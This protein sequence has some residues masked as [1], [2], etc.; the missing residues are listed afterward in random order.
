MHFFTHKRHLLLCCLICSMFFVLTACTSTPQ[1]EPVPPLKETRFLMG[2]AI[3]LTLF[4]GQDEAT[5]AKAFDAIEALERDLSLNASG[6]LLDEVNDASGIAPVAVNPSMFDVVEKGLYY[7][8]L[9]EGSF[10]IS[11]GPL[12]KLWNIGFPD[13]RVPSQSEIDATLPL[14]DYEQVQLDRHA[15]T[16]FLT[17]PGMKLDLGS[18]AKGYAA[19]VVATL[20]RE[21]GVQHALIDLG[22]NIYTLGTKL[23][24][25]PWKVGVQDPFNPRGKI[26]G[27][28]PVANQSI[29]T[30]GIYERFLEADGKKYHH[31]LNPS[32]GYPFDNEI[33]GITIISDYS[34]DGD[35]LSTSVFSKG[36]EEGLTFVE[37]LD[38]IDAIFI[39]KDSKV[40]V[41]KGI[42]DSFVLDN[43][44]FTLAN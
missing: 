20:L 32:T 10:D 16:I 36:I 2:T 39:S 40:Y 5:L 11:V 21:A 34:V 33:A 13:A 35:A 18:I 12:V 9:T 41:T 17:T 26:I 44:N 24:G 7:S 3:T 15:Q 22:G 23:D 6:T 28:I 25:S 30:S 1:Q 29:V 4:D 8:Q 43:P 37:S 31:I 38:G 42:K 27:Y 19:D 14:V